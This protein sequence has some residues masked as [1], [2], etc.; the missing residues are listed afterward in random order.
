MNLRS[1]PSTN[2][3]HFPVPDGSEPEPN[4][5]RLLIV[6][7][8][9][10]NRLILSRLLNISGY[11]TFEAHDGQQAL[12]FILSHPLDLVIMDLEMPNMDG[13]EA[14]HQIRALRDPRLASLPILAASGNPQAQT[15]RQVLEAGANAFLTKPFAHPALLK[16]IA[17]LLS[18]SPA[19]SSPTA[20]TSDRI[21]QSKSQSQSLK[22]PS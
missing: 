18:P 17:S 19:P 7:D 11:L 12:D 2:T 4:Q 20:P 9:S 3:A 10:A 1:N 21:P 22:S 5:F 8:Q 6:D 14:T 13:L 15:Q 16:T